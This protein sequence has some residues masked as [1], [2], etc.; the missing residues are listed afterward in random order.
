VIKVYWDIEIFRTME[1]YTKL[2][3]NNKRSNPKQ[4]QALGS[5]GS[6]GS[7][8]KYRSESIVDPMA[9]GSSYSIKIGYG[10]LLEE[11]IC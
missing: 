9:L 4:K 8:D 10:K 5:Y 2:I 6:T 1:S 11:D 3:S 7:Y